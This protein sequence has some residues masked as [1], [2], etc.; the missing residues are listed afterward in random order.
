MT[1]GRRWPDRPPYLLGLLLSGRA[2]VVVGAGALV[3]RRLPHLLRAGAQVTVIAPEATPAVQRLAGRGE[4][5]WDQRPYRTG[6]LEHAWYV[7]AATDS[8]EVNAEVAADAEARHTFCVRADRAELGSA[9]TPATA[10]VE[11]VSLAVL[12]PGGPRRAAAVRDAVVEALAA[13]FRRPAA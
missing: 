7:L 8:V 9:F 11:G 2:V 12:A 13:L 5:T 10:E 3:Q 6:D 4:L 1:I